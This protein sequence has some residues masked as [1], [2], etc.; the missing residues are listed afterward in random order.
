VVVSSRRNYHNKNSNGLQQGEKASTSGMISPSLAP[1]SSFHHSPSSFSTTTQNDDI[2]T[3]NNNNNN[4]N[5]NNMITNPITPST[6]VS[7]PSSLD[8]R[9]KRNQKNDHNHMIIFGDDTTDN[10]VLKNAAVLP[11]GNPAPSAAFILPTQHQ[12]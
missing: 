8:S 3:N 12:Q 1:V 10:I 5:K 6:L 4:K 11:R 9:S 2:S 7:V